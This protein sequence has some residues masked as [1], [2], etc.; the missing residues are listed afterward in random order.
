VP[1]WLASWVTLFAL[2]L[3]RV[4]LLYTGGE[5]IRASPEQQ[6]V[7]VAGVVVLAVAAVGAFAWLQLAPPEAPRRPERLADGLPYLV[8]S[9]LAGVAGVYQAQWTGGASSRAALGAETLPAIIIAGCWLGSGRA[10]VIGIVLAVAGLSGMEF[11]LTYQQAEQ[12]TIVAAA[13]GAALL[14]LAASRIVHLAAARAYARSGES[15]PASEGVAG[16]F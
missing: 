4:A 2:T 5:S 10:N 7:I 1:G 16:A 12:A 9:L 6:W 15:S 3:A 11:V 14:A 13:A 8:C